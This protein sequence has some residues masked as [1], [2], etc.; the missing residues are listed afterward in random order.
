MK[1][2]HESN[3][4]YDTQRQPENSKLTAE[5]SVESQSQDSGKN[6]FEYRSIS[7]CYF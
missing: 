4:R 6:H 3:L 1:W 7:S 5:K 2:A